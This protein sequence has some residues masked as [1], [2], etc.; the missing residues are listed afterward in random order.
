MFRYRNAWLAVLAGLVLLEL[1]IT[2]PDK[3]L[4]TVMLLQALTVPILALVVAHVARKVL[5]NTVDLSALIAQAS[6]TSEGA[7]RVVLAVSIVLAVMMMIFAGQVRAQ[8]VKT[9]IPLGAHIYLPLLK[10]EQVRFWDDHPASELLP[11]LVEHESCITLKHSRCWN[12]ASRLKTSREEGAGLGQITRAWTAD[13]NLRFDSLA[14]MRDKHPAL[15]EWSWSN[16]YQRPD[17]Q[18]RAVVLMSRD[19]YLRIRQLVEDPN[20]ALAM[21]DAAYNGGFNGVQNDRRACQ[22]KAGCDPKK[23]FAH[24]EMTCTKSKAALYGN[25][26]ACDINRHHVADVLLVR[27]FKYRAMMRT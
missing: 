18:L 8:D 20:E 22:I 3:G 4:S 16:V 11:A 21:A 13:G 17:L 19:N 5:F 6:K 2:D 1:V 12:P 7:G 9:F 15:Q 27:P 25:R 23:W 26:S 14:E 24:V 10:A